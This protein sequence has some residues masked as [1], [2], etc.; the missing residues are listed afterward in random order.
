[1][2][3]HHR[4]GRDHCCMIQSEIKAQIMGFFVRRGIVLHVLSEK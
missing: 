2:A 3:G 1:M 4:V